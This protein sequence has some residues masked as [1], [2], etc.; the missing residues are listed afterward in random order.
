VLGFPGGDYDVYRP[1]MSANVIDFD[2]HT[3][4]LA[5][6]ISPGLYRLA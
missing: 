2:S 5:W 3:A 6:S 1:T 4:R